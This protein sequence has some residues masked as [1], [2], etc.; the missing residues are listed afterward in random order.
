MS[1]MDPGA[2]PDGTP[3]EPRRLALLGATG[4][5]GRE[6]VRA[7]SVDGHQVVAYARR[8]AAVELH[9]GVRAVGGDLTDVGALADA[10]AGCD[11]LVVA[12]SS[13]ERGF[14]ARAL[15]AAADAA[16]EAGV[17]RVVLSSSLGVRDTQRLTSWRA[18]LFART[19]LRT[20]L[21]DRT[22]AEELVDRTGLTWTTVLPIRL[23]EGAPLL[24]HSLAPLG[25]VK[26]V[27]GLPLLPYAN[28]GRALVD[29]AASGAFGGQEVVLSSVGAMRIR[30]GA[31][32]GI[33]PGEDAGPGR[34]T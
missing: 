5:V 24:S 4:R 29:L 28:A 31:H 21:E 7:A 18:Q 17:G 16:R 25:E 9:E 32:P 33:L 1:T 11:V 6:V 23:R 8:P 12:L 10:M 30:P 13:K 26:R 14:L 27:V 22:R 15:P 3:P 19:L 2:A 34:A 20:E